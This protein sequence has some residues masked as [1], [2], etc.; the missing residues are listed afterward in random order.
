MAFQPVQRPAEA[1]AITGL[2]D[3]RQAPVARVVEG[4]GARCKKRWV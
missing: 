2:K 1:W 3:K 4:V